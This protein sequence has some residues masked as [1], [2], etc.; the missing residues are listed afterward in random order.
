MAIDS[1]ADDGQVRVQPVP[2]RYNAAEGN[3]YGDS[4]ARA[5]GKDEECLFQ[6]HRLPQSIW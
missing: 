6:D 4:S 1:T 5:E 3:H 2:G